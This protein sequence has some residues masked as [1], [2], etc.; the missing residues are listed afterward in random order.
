VHTFT[1]V[2]LRTAG[3]QLIIAQDTATNSTGNATVLVTPAAA[4]QFILVA[5][6]PFSVT[7]GTP[8]DVTVVAL[9]PYHN[10]ATGYVGTVKFT[11]SDGG[12]AL[13]GKYTFTAAD[14][15]VHTFAG[16]ILRKKGTQTITVFDAVNHTILGTTRI[17]VL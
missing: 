13:P 7:A 9:D 11:S 17:D 14:Q 1:G 4:V 2:V 12:A 15:G 5:S 3:S 8:F 6:T 10:V 16:L